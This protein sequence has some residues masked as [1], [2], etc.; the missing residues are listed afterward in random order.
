[1]VAGNLRSILSS[2]LSVTNLCNFH[3]DLLTYPKRLPLRSSSFKVFLIYNK[4]LKVKISYIKS[5]FWVGPLG[6]F[7]L[8]KY[9]QKNT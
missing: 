7:L 4:K 9:G 2:S 6:T 5:K 3:I 1:M 8:N